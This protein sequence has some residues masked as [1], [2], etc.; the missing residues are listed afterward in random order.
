MMTD[1]FTWVREVDTFPDATPEEVADKTA[2]RLSIC[3]HST[4]TQDIDRTVDA[5]RTHGQRIDDAERERLDGPV[6]E[7]GA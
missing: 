6:D 4:T 3:S 2:I 5:L 1:H 7:R